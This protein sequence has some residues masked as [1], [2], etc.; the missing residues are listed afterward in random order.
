MDLTRNLKQA[1][2]TGKVIFGQR[3][4]MGAC[5]KGDARLVLV[6]AN[7]PEAFLSDIV[8]SHPGVPVH[9]VQMVNRQLGAACARPFSISALCIIDPGQSELMSLQHNI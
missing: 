6:A 4:T 9:R 7:C 2:S 8:D 5:S 1:L 3:E